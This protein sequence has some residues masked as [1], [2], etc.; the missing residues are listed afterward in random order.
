M[1]DRMALRTSSIRQRNIFISSVLFTFAMLSLVPRFAGDASYSKNQLFQAEGFASLSN[2]GVSLLILWCA[3]VRRYIW[4]WFAMLTVVTLWAFP[5]LL[6]PLFEYKIDITIHEWIS[7]AWHH[8]G[9]ARIYA[10]NVVLFSIMVIALLLPFNSFF[11][12]AQRVPAEQG[13]V[14][15]KTNL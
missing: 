7:D 5:I 12:Q 11:G 6:L 15:D 14:D 2:I 10:E 8:P 9:S 13:S 3:F 1:I 4:A